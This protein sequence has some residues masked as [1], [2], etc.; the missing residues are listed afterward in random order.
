MHTA[1]FHVSTVQRDQVG[2]SREPAHLRDRPTRCDSHALVA[3]RVRWVHLDSKRVWCGAV[4][5]AGSFGF[6]V[7]VVRWAGSFDIEVSVWCGAWAHSVS[8]QPRC[9]AFGMEALATR[10][11][12]GARRARLPCEASRAGLVREVLVARCIRG[13]F[14][15]HAWYG[16]FARGVAVSSCFARDTRASV[17]EHTAHCG[18]HCKRRVTRCTHGLRR[19]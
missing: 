14:L 11:I 17:V 6:D 9:G 2:R 7:S 8:M 13:A 5:W 18:A 19:V 3:V 1:A 10:F 16:S 15:A 4:G 12:R